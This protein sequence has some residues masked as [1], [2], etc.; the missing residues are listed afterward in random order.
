M[1]EVVIL[2]TNVG[3]AR[4]LFAKRQASARPEA[5]FV[6]PISGL[7]R[8]GGVVVRARGLVC[9]CALSLACGTVVSLK[10]MAD[11]EYAARRDGGP[12]TAEE[13][14][15]LSMIEARAA[16]AAL[17]YVTSVEPQRGYSARPMAIAA[18]AALAPVLL[19]KARAVG[20]V[21]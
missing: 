21:T 4:E 18:G 1:L 2:R 14:I 3:Q 9:R 19:P 20:A 17:G 16:L 11:W 5:L 15:R 10:E 6:A 7:M 8:R 13:V 12:E